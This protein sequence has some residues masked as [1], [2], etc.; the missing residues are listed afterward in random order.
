MK[1]TAPEFVLFLKDY[2]TV[3][4]IEK[5][6]AENTINSYR[7]DISSLFR[8]LEETGI[9]DLNKVD[10]KVLTSFF[11]LIS[12]IGLSSTSS[13][14]YFS[15]LKSFFNFLSASNY[16]TANPVEKLSPPKIGRKLPS[17]LS[18]KEMEKILSAASGDDKFGLRDRAILELFYA[19]GLRI[20]ELINI[21]IS[22]LYFDDD[23]IRVI[24]KGDKERIVPVGSSA[25]NHVNNYLQNSRPILE[26]RGKSFNFLF[27]NTRGTKLSRM[28]VWKIVAYYVKDAKIKKEVHPHTFRHTFATHLL[29]G[30]ADLRAVQEMLG[31][32]SISTTQIYTHVDR[33]F[34][35]QEHKMYHPRG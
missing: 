11:K 21:K 12:G 9:N 6:L 31:H 8:F 5:N 29:E 30:G 17:V 34:I 35:K 28:G 22:D 15:S 14:R 24:G 32:A 26:K 25:V 16:I 33:D 4:R 13:A 19:C 3:L 23:V 20:S 10:S 2:T 18:I 7:N 27:L 1:A